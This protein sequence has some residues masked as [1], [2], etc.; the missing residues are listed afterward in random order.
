MAIFHDD[1]TIFDY[2]DATI[3]VSAEIVSSEAKG[4]NVRK[5]PEKN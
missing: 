3:E 4:Q 1:Y 5:L 2:N